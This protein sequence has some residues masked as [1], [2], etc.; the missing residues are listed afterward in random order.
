[1]SFFLRLLKYRLMDEGG[2]DGGGSGGGDGGAGGTGG[3][4]GAGGNGGE[5]NWRES[6]PEQYAE[7]ASLSAEQ[8]ADLP[9]LIDQFVNSQRLVGSSIRIPGENA[10]DD[11]KKRFYEKLMGVDGV[12]RIPG[13]DADDD[14]M[15]QF[16]NKLGRPEKAG[17]YEIFTPDPKDLPDGIKLGEDLNNDAFKETAHKLGLSANQVKG[18]S[19][20]YTEDSIEKATADAAKTTEAMDALKK[21]YGNQFEGR[22]E[23]A[24]SVINKFGSEYALN[25]L[26]SQIGNYPGL[27]MMLA[28]IALL[29]TEDGLQRQLPNGEIITKTATEIQAEIDDLTLS[30]AYTDKHEDGHNKVIEKVRKLYEQQEILSNSKK[31]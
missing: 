30:K 3:D 11:D 25:D 31:T 23:M 28:D 17:E 18:L 8:V 26:N 2:G 14:A 24:K 27:A 5:Y 9:A 7:E 13:T 29:T 12:T 16:Y 10:D 1:M 6:I 20:W 22:I 4:G 21:E 15:G 19:Q